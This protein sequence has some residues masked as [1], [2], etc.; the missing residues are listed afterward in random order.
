MK[1]VVKLCFVA[2]LILVCECLGAQTVQV[3][4]ENGITYSSGADYELKLD[5]AYPSEGPRLHP[6][7]VFV[8]GNWESWT[9]AAYGMAIR[10]AADRGYVSVSIDHRPIHAKVQG[11][12]KYPFPAQVCDVKNAICWMRTNAARYNLDP[13]RIG[14]VGFSS[15]A[16]LVLM[17]GL[18][19]DE[20]IQCPPLGDSSVPS[21]L[22]AVVNLSGITDVVDKYHASYP[23]M[24]V[25]LLGGTPEEFPAL[26]REA[27]PVNHIGSNSPPILTI[28]GTADPYIPLR[29]AELLDQRMR[30]AGRQHTLVVIQ[31]GGHSDRCY[32]SRVWTFLGAVLHPER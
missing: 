13:R 28:H 3:I 14:A 31:N 24:M 18:T 11:K 23:Y 15:G 17:A 19:G 32:D 4:V 10:E 29:E 20:S 16:Y 26:Y 9:R 2:I 21:D 27:S 6:G 25:D 12:P 7:L 5:V 1:K 22:Q 8:H 30:E